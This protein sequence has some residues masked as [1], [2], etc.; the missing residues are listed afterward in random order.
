MSMVSEFKEFALKGNVMDLAV[1]V[2]IG[3]AFATITKSLVDDIIMPIV[4]F[5]VGGEINF[6]NMLL[7]LGDVP[8]GVAMTYD[9]LKEA[10]VPVLAYG[11]FITVLINFLILAFIIFMMV[12]VV[13]KMRRTEAVEEAVVEPSE[14]VQLLREISA[15]LSNTHI[16]K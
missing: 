4:A 2:I 6:K 11:S 13:N 16:V 5:I 9:A 15:K 12:R 8:N 14:E 10:G 3:G 1:G 7:V